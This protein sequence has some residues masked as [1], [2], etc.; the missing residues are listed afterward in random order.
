[1]RRAFS[2]CIVA[3]S[4]AA[5]APISVTISIGNPTP[6]ATAI[7]FAAPSIAPRAQSTP[8]AKNATPVAAP[9]A[10]ASN[11]ITWLDASARIGE[12]V[13][14]RGTISS[15]SKDAGS[16]TFFIN[17]DSS[18]TSFYAVSFRHTWENLRGKCVEITGKI[19]DFRGR[20]QIVVENKEQLK[21]C[22]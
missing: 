13:C 14:V 5:C 7:A 1:M 4:L 19:V 22:S 21:E 16:S 6:T 17:F 2:F 15:A 18:R 10:T 8:A 20:A 12:T 3:I 11:C 9:P